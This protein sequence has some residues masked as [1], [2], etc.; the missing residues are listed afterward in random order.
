MRKADG[1]DSEL[2]RSF[3]LSRRPANGGVCN[4]TFV[5]SILPDIQIL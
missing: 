2:S 4:V 1:I 5:R 3:R